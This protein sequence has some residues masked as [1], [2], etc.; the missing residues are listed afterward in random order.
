MPAPR[1]PQ[2]GLAPLAGP[3][4]YVLNEGPGHGAALLDVVQVL[5]PAVTL[6]DGPFDTLGHDLVQLPVGQ[7]QLAL[8]AQSGGHVGEHRVDKLA[9]VALHVGGVQVGTEQAHSTVDVVA[10]TSRGDHPVLHVRGS[11]PPDRE[12]VTEVDVGH[13]QAVA[14]DAGKGCDVGD[15]FK[16]VVVDDGAHHLLAGIDAPPGLHA[17]SSGLGDDPDHVAL[18]LENLL[19][20]NHLSTSLRLERLTQIRLVPAIRCRKGPG[21]SPRR[22]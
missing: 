7:A 20:V 8:G 16:G 12:A 5:L 18:P 19:P 4:G 21:P 13:G 17:L 1:V 15:L 9:D 10:H 6:P 2:L 14:H 22:A 11:D 3:V